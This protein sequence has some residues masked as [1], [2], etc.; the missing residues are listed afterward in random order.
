MSLIKMR[1]AVYA[2]HKRKDGSYPVKIVV[3]F[4]GKERKLATHIVA[5]AKDLTRTLHLKQGEVLSLANEEIRKMREACSDIPYYDTVH[6]D[7]DWVVNYI[8]AK[9]AKQYFRLDFF[10]FADTFIAEKN[11]G[12][13]ENYRQS[14]RAFA[15]FLDK[16]EIDINF[17]TRSMVAEFV[18]FL[19]NEPIMYWD[20]ETGKIT[21]TNK[22]KTSGAQASRHV[23]RLGAIYK[24]AKRK[25]NDDD[26]GIINIPRSPFENH[27]ID[28]PFA[29]GQRPLSHEIIQELIS[30][31]TD[32]DVKRRSIDIAVISFALMGPN[33]ADLVQAK[34]PKDGIWIYN[35]SKT[36]DR[37]PDKAEMRV[38]IPE[39]LAPYIER[40][41]DRRRKEW[42]GRLHE[43]KNPTATI[44]RGLKL[45]C[46]QKG[47]EPFTFYA[48]R[49][50]WATIARKAGVNKSIV[51]EGL[52]HVGDFKMT[53]IYA[54]RPWDYINDE[55]AKVLAL[56]NWD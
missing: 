2:N 10:K 21:A 37:R 41:T 29:Q 42:L 55:N 50:S 20:K 16:Q 51:D 5:E 6:Q 44:N 8:K 23:M 31:K 33:L 24:A 28:T 7:V 26:S 46:E 12:T 18:E 45:W 32:N 30:A 3:Y 48:V 25:Y 27:E 54:E 43:T 1:P 49:K 4:K 39:C 40:L 38:R 14:A 17:I 34:P 13:A 22:R 53:D 11:P 47:Y 56:F 15:R 36:R 9:L 52:A 35:R 19:N